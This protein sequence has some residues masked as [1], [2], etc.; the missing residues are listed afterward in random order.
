MHVYICVYACIYIYIYIY[1]YK[2]TYICAFARQ[3]DARLRSMR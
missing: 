1:I 3:P 2:P